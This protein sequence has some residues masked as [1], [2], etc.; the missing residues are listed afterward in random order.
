[1][2]WSFIVSAVRL[3]SDVVRVGDSF[4]L[5]FSPLVWSFFKDYFYLFKYI[6]CI[7]D[8]KHGNIHGFYSFVSTVPFLVYST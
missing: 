6:I 1:M 2:G 8:G 3:K 4:T 7:E 5:C